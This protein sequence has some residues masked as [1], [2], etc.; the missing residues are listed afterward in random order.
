MIG[1]LLVFGRGEG[2]VQ[3]VGE[4]VAWR[5]ILRH[6]GDVERCGEVGQGIKHVDAV[7]YLSREDEVAHDNAAVGYAVIVGGEG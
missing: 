7:L 5:K 3:L 4:V 6:E 2:T 1:D